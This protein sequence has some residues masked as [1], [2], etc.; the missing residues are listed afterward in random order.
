MRSDRLHRSPTGTAIEQRIKDLKIFRQIDRTS[1]PPDQRTVTG[2]PPLR[3]NSRSE[4]REPR[5]LYS[6]LT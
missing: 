1:D 3:A 5:T 2:S 6:D 4:R